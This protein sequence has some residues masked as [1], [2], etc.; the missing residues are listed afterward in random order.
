M[1]KYNNVA[2]QVEPKRKLL[3]EKQ[4]QGKAGHCSCNTLHVRI[5]ENVLD[6]PLVLLCI[7]NTSAIHTVPG[8]TRCSLP[9][10]EVASTLLVF[11]CRSTFV[12]KSVISTWLDG[13]SEY[14]A[15][16]LRQNIQPT[17]SAHLSIQT[18]KL[19]ILQI[20][21]DVTMAELAQA[22]SILKETLAK[23]AALEAQFDEANTKKVIPY[24][25]FG[26]RF[27]A[28]G[29]IIGRTRGY[30][31]GS[32]SNKWSS[33]RRRKF[34]KDLSKFNRATRNTCD[35]PISPLGLIVHRP[36]TTFFLRSC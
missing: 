25:S 21:L 22:Q 33:P 6:I 4:V 20:E 23:V 16:Q 36:F 5:H 24:T 15:A 1:H 28:E 8:A 27:L 31:G 12:L 3:A 9:P 11:R 19:S 34:A 13:G 10:L 32:R 2:K 17:I 29:W 30:R 35:T 14:A 18:L 7:S 26:G